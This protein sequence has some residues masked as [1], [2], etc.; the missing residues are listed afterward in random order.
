LRP[1]T[2]QA[3][4][5]WLGCDTWPTPHHKDEERFFH[6]VNALRQDIGTLDGQ[7]D[8]LMDL[9]RKTLRETGW[10]VNADHTD[11]KLRKRM[12]HI[13]VILDFCKTCGIPRSL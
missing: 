12:S 6:F 8:D 11:E 1:Q 5:K 2:L 7:E 13:W 3:L 9:M 4:R 10:T